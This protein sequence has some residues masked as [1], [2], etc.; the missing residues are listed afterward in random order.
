MFK[1][2]QASIQNL[3]EKLS[4]WIDGFITSLPNA[5][6]ALIFMT[7]AYVTSRYVK[8]YI[9]QLMNRFSKDRSINSLIASIGSLIIIAFALFISLGIMNLDKALT[10][11]LA[12]AGVAG[13]AVG[14]ALQ[15]PLV[16]TLS[17]IMMSMRHYYNIGDWVKSN[18]YE[19]KIERISLR[20]TELQ[21]PSGEKIILPNKMIVN[22]P[23]ENYSIAGKRRI[24]I[25]CGIA[26][27][28]D[29]D[30]VIEITKN[31]I[32]D[33]F[34]F[35]HSKN[36]V[37]FY[38]TGFGS[39]SIDFVVRF[40]INTKSLIAYKAHMS[41]A[42]VAIKKAFD[43]AQI[44][45]P[46]PIQ[47]LDMGNIQIYSQQTSSGPNRPPSLPNLRGEHIQVQFDHN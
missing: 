4:G 23:F 37:E 20:T 10:S 3:K 6:L 18:N 1:V 9:G 39:S 19:G 21:R 29:L 46:F 17:G 34:E 40:W 15:D 14:L 24:E 30:R 22:A 12:T 27:S 35:I 25:P 31:A 26:Y 7:I 42:I 2:F 45:I 47:T 44:T 33:K 11:L 41:K 36:D 32:V 38:Y 13:L 5:V 16:N 43:K 8:K 28:S